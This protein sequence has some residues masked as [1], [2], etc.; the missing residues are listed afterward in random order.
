MT[1]RKLSNE[2]LYQSY[3][4]RGREIA[5]NIESGKVEIAKMALAVCDIRHGGKSDGYYT[6]A[7]YADDIGVNR[8]NV[9]TWV[10][11]YRDILVKS[12]KENPSK[13]DWHTATRVDKILGF[14]MQSK[15]FETSR[16]KSY[17][18]DI[19]KKQMKEIFV[20]AQDKESDLYMVY[21][22]RRYSKHLVTVAQDLEDNFSGNYDITEIY[23]ELSK[24]LKILK[25]LK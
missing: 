24:A 8:K 2:Q 5:A 23:N 11:L 13:E 20:E 22:L 6:I 3:V 15:G 14:A 9:A 7:D 1:R 16:G 21:R 10:T 17:K 19:P 18:S 4:N 12:G 25:R